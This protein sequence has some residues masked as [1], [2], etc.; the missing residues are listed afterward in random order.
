MGGLLYVCVGGGGGG[1]RL[2]WPPLSNYLGGRGW[3]PGHLFLRLCKVSHLFDYN[4]ILA[5]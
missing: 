3:P 5:F 2:C 4:R 1:Q